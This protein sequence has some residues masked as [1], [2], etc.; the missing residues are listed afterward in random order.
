MLPALSLSVSQCSYC[1]LVENYLANRSI[2]SGL[3]V[4]DIINGF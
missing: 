4:T 3:F 1:K 2:Y